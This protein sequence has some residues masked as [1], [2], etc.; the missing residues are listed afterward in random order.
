MYFCCL[1][2]LQQ[3]QTGSDVDCGYMAMGPEG[4]GEDSSYAGTM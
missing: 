1:M 2:M 3:S 4:L